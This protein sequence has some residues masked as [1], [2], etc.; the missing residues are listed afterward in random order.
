MTLLGNNPV[1]S[2]TKI[3]SLTPLH[4][5]M[6]D[7]PCWDP[8]ILEFFAAP[9]WIAPESR[10]QVA[11][12]WRG[13]MMGYFITLDDYDSVRQWSVLI[14]QWLYNR[15]MPL[16][17][18]A[19]Q[20]WP[21][22]A[23]ETFRA[24]VNQGW[25]KTASDRLDPAERIPP[26]APRPLPLRIRK[27]IRALSQAELDDYRMRFDDAFQVANAAPDAPGQIFF[28]IH[29]DWCLHYQEAFLLWHRA[30]LI[31]FETLLGAPVPYWNF[32]AQ[33]AGVPGNQAAGLPQAFID[34]TYIH[35]CTGE[36]RP[37]PLRF[38]A[39]KGGVSKACAPASPGCID[40]FWVQ[41]DPA[42]YISGPTHDKKVAL[43]LQYQQQIQ[44]ALAFTDFSHPQGIGHP[45]AN[46]TSFNPPPPDSEY[47]YRDYNFDGAYEQ[48]HDNYHGWVGPDMADNAYTAFDPVFW[49]Y[50]ANIDRI[51]EFWLRANGTTMTVTG[52]FPLHPF[53][54]R[55]AERLEYVDR[56]RFIF[57]SIGD[58]A[59]DCRALGY[60]FARPVDPDFGSD[61]SLAGEATCPVATSPNLS[62]APPGTDEL[63]IIFDD[64][65][66]TFESYAIDAFV[67]LPSP[68]AADVDG[69][70]PH[71]AGRLARIGM[72]VADDKGRCITQ[73]VRRMIDATPVAR[74]LG[75]NPGAPVRLSLRVTEL[76]TGRTVLPEVQQSLPGFAGRIV[77]S[78]AGWA[79]RPANP[80]ASA[81]GC[82]H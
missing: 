47:V 21:D 76:A 24:W 79:A 44:R 6:P 28:G 46:I 48:P 18:D 68:G 67:N 31:A 9:Y 20:Y 77:W 11:R 75:L 61:A 33:G 69:D 19:S 39:A 13:C 49:S 72:G 16:T 63:L 62:A 57:T 42:L 59:R 55:L 27:D 29:G 22:E 54:G 43:T 15:Q 32:Y 1:L 36:R 45:W 8:S 51:F 5:D 50:H 71:Y 2:S 53:A 10:L 3:G 52:N 82:C 60:D 7:R 74:C 66:C 80:A 40:C 73:G 26:P 23:M 37:N 4:S 30:Y 35:P 64:V 58:M 12:Q 56:R 78:H 70:N 65:R 25:R 14:Y 81:A 34:E 38:A 17:G 41:R